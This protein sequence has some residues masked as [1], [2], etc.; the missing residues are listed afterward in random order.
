MSVKLNNR[1]YFRL[2]SITTLSLIVVFAFILALAST[3]YF[4]E[5]DWTREARHSISEP[6]IKLLQQI[7][8]PL[9][10]TSYARGD[11]AYR[12]LIRNYVSK[13]QS[14]KSD[15]T[16]S[17]VNPD[18]APDIVR[19]LGIRINGEMVFEYQGRTEHARAA[20]ENTFINTL[21]RL[22]RGQDRW[23]A[24][25]TGH[26]ERNLMGTANHDMGTFGEYLVNRGFNIQPVNLLEIQAIPDN[27]AIVVLTGS[28]IPFL[29]DESTKLLDY[30]HRGGNFLYLI[31]PE[32]KKDISQLTEFLDIKIEEGT[33]IDIASQR[34]N[35]DDPTVT[36]ITASLYGTHP[37]VEGFEFTTL[38]PQATMIS[39]SQS[40]TWSVM[41]LLMTGDHTWLETNTLE[42][43]VEYNSDTDIKGPLTIGLAL[44][45]Q[46]ESPVNK[47][48]SSTEQRI[49]VIGD[50]DF[51]SNTY[52]ENS[53]NLDL[54]IR[55]FD[56][57]N[58][59][60]NLIN[61]PARLP[62]DTQLSV[63]TVVIGS[64]GL[65]FLIILPLLFIS[66]GI[67]SGW[68]RRQA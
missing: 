65:I 44:N 68:R 43:E 18:S 26:G 42:N 23:V 53:G 63:S 41:P 5:F 39:A 35:I 62:I 11:S 58:L 33:V 31:D 55:I 34:I 16:L 59:D 27:T 25:I 57:L 9:H 3:Q 50:G 54:G 52:L 48:T 56:W 49:I 2:N 47:T 15:I 32:N 19:K 37:V 40:E 14:I 29:K 30:L 13:Y 17:F 6:G 8:G 45:R 46:V 4:I 10:I 66:I 60:D 21:V 67:Y 7:I 38:F 28:Q 12:E 64:I 1:M 24:Y 61:I 20:D 51:L 22:T 36:L